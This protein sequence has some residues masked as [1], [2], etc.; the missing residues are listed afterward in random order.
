[1]VFQLA[2]AITGPSWAATDRASVS[3]SRIGPCDGAKRALTN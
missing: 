1:M 2:P 3:G